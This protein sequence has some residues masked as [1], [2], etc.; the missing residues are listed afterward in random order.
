[1]NIITLTEENLPKEHICCAMSSKSSEKGVNAKKEWLACC[2]KEGLKFK[3]LDVKGKVMIEYIP[4]ENAWLPIDADGYIIINCF[5]V[6]GSFKGH[7]YG[8]KLLAECEADAKAQ[9]YKGV[10]AMVGNGKKKPYLTDKA[11]MLYQG[12]EVCDTCPPL[13]DLVV[14][15]FDESTPLPRFAEHARS[16]SLGEGI[17]GIDI[18][19]TAQCPFT[20]PYIEILKPVIVASNYPVRTHHINSKKLAKKHIFPVTTY[21]VF[22][23]GKFVT[24]EIL[25]PSKLEKMIEKHEQK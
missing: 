1:M 21:S 8:K 17:T 2:I 12:Y 3:K 23:D 6:S 18:F 22:V 9:G 4:A 24:N 19:Y 25:T 13:L 15:R 16:G 5:W 14:K 11:F 7:G 10:V 20:I